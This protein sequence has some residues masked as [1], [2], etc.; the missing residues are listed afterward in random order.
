LATTGWAGQHE[1]VDGDERRDGGSGDGDETADLHRL[2]AYAT[3]LADGIE[4][5]LP[6]WVEAQVARIMIAWAGSVPDEV[7][8]EAGRAG[9]AARDELGPRLRALLAL[10]IDEQRG[11]PMTIVR[12]AA[13][14]PTAV[15]RSAGVPPVERDAN[16]ERQFPDDDY[17]LV[18]TR[19]ADLDPGLHELGINWG[20]AKAHV[21][22]QRRRKE[23]QR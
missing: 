20:A 18:P 17:D 14:Y 4:T 23:G 11:N 8:A 9:R 15:L 2:A 3:D 7:R 1:V 5:A 16:A 13:A 21:H 10:D 6:R 19:F 22:L 12:S